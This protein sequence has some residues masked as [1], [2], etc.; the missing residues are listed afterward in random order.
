MGE[1]EGHFLEQEGLKTKYDRIILLPGAFD[2]KGVLKEAVR[3]LT[4]TYG[5]LPKQIVTA[6]SSFSSAEGSNARI[7][8]VGDNLGNEVYSATSQEGGL[9]KQL[10]VAHSWGAGDLE[11]IFGRIRKKFADD[12]SFNRY[13]ID[14]FEIALISPAGVFNKPPDSIKFLKSVLKLFSSNAIRGINSFLVAPLAGV[15]QGKLNTIL[16]E[17]FPEL[18]Q[19]KDGVDYFLSP[20]T[21]PSAYTEGKRGEKGRRLFDLDRKLEQAIQEGDME[22]V[23]QLV[24]QRGSLLEAEI[25]KVY[26]EVN[27]TDDPEGN[28]LANLINNVPTIAKIMTGSPGRIISEL[29]SGGLPVYFLIPEFDV[30]FPAHESALAQS[31]PRTMLAGFQHQTVSLES[32]SAIRALMEILKKVDQEQQEKEGYLSEKRVFHEENP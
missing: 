3:Q 19:L 10:V 1:V 21:A 12:E 17:V 14:H 32:G 27:K 8:E 15:K 11:T 6:S 4:S 25:D 13:V 22:S 31:G 9:K 18:A 30:I 16:R 5:Y 20:L 24:R 26:K 2:T 29:H 23:A 28:M 7:R